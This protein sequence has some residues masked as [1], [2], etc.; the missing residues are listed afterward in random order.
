V[1]RDGAEKTIPLTWRKCHGNARNEQPE[2]SSPDALEGITVENV[3][4]Q[5]AGSWDCRLALRA[6]W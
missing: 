6:L 1:F 4:A 2:S 5:T 3:T